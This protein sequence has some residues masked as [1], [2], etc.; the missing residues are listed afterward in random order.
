MNWLD[1]VLLLVLAAS[2]VTSFRKGFTREAIGL[3]SVTVA[4][5][6]GT[7]FYGTA[8]AFLLPYVSSPTVA[9]FAGFFLIFFGV[10]LLGGLVSYLAGRFLRVTGLSVFD[11]AL[12]AGFGILRGVVISVALILG[13]MA[14]S[15][16]ENPPAAVVNSR[17][18]PYVAYAARAI[19][20]VAPH[21]LRESFLKRY[22]QV[23]NS[24]GRAL[25]KRAPDAPATE[26]GENGQRI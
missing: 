8:G 16:G 12:G 10:L 15:Q 11:H 2:V 25:E 23:K 4:L 6:A 24:W 5:A 13:I 18:A 26:K 7:W 14:F 22:A 1:I 21:E 3:V 9:H 19:A 20:A 17:V